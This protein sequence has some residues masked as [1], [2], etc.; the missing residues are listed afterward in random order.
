MEWKSVLE[1][2]MSKVATN[3]EEKREMSQFGWME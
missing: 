3:Q 1:Q 2:S